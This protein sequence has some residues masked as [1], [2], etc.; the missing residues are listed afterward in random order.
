MRLTRVCSK[1]AEV[2]CQ[3]HAVKKVPAVHNP[4]YQPLLEYVQTMHPAAAAAGGPCWDPGPCS[5]RP[6]HHLHRCGW[7]NC[8]S[9]NSYF[10]LAAEATQSCNDT[11]QAG[12]TAPCLHAL[13]LLGPFFC[14]HPPMQEIYLG[15]AEVA[16]FMKVAVNYKTGTCLQVLA[17]SPLRDLWLRTR[18]TAA[19]SS[20]ATVQTTD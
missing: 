7:H 4:G 19:H 18:S 1:A 12:T 17:P 5:H 8:H 20:W 11:Y 2:T 14:F 6:T 10:R 9:Q 15:Y 16:M 13:V 3:L